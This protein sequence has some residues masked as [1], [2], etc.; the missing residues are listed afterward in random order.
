MKGFLFFFLLLSI[1][2]LFIHSIVLGGE[3]VEV[4]RPADGKGAGGKKRKKNL[5]LVYVLCRPFYL[6]FYEATPQSFFSSFP[7]FCL[8]DEGATNWR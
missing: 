3:E 7:P 2:H 4:T 8:K 1:F 6:F 5:F